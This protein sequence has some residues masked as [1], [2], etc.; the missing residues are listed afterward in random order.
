MANISDYLD[1]RG[2]VPF[3]IAPF[4][5]VD[6]LILTELVY[7]DFSGLVPNNGLDD[8]VDIKD[9]CEQFF[10]KNTE[11]EIMALNSSTKVAPFLMKKMVN[12]KRF[13]DVKMC[14]F[15]NEIDQDNQS[16]FSAMTYILPDGTYF[17]A[18]RGTDNTIVGWKEDFNMS[19]LSETWGQMSAV[20]YLNGLF[21]G[22]FIKLRVGGHS[23]GGNFAVYASAFCEENIQK[24]IIE[25][26]SND[27][28]GFLPEVMERE[29]YR[30]IL[31]KVI[32]TMPEQSVVGIL[33]ENELDNRYV[34]SSEKGPQQHDPMSWQVTRDSFELTDNLKQISIMLDQTLKSWIFG[35]DPEERKEFV[36]ILFS[37]IES[38]GAETLDDISNN[39]IKS[40]QEMGKYMKDLTPQ[41]Q[42]DFR[43]VLKR[44]VS[45]SGEAVV[46]KMHSNYNSLQVKFK[47]LIKK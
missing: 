42:K 4:N 8:F 10:D 15:V 26:Y 5:E 28:P 12:G 17:A 31:P 41:Q 16:Q 7:T 22:F 38:S 43:N 14:C 37:A 6:N 46:D 25:V 11:E 39:K 1:W 3:S 18:Y 29:G 24:K 19:F 34:L 23:K 35:M 32:S 45:S 40:M 36:D 21:D 27:G 47:N 13:A 20:K 2:D 33:L 44:F 30:R 9:V